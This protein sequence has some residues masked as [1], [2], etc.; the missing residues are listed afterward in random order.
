MGCSSAGCGTI[1][2]RCAHLCGGLRVVFGRRVMVLR[3]CCQTSPL[4]SASSPS[5]TLTSPTSPTEQFSG[6]SMLGQWFPERVCV[7]VEVLF[8]FPPNVAPTLLFGARAGSPSSSPN[9]MTELKFLSV[10]SYDPDIRRLSVHVR[11]LACY[12]SQCA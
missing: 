2:A 10:A 7:W 12:C 11:F 3:S 1:I 9:P 6:L 4:S 8:A 5:S